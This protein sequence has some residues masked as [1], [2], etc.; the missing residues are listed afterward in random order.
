[1]RPSTIL[2]TAAPHSKLVAAG[3]RPLRTAVENIEQAVKA[4]GRVEALDRRNCRRT[5]EERFS[6]RRM[7][8]D[9]LAI[10]RA[11]CDRDQDLI[12]RDSVLSD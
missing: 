2:T 10:Y 8:A 4:V 5:F 7:C 6:A 11:L 3:N 1:M 9:Y 12:S